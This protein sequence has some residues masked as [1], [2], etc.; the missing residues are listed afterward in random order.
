[1]Y[2][3]TA[4]DANASINIAAEFAAPAEPNFPMRFRN[5]AEFHASETARYE[6]KPVTDPTYPVTDEQDYMWAKAV[7]HNL[8]NMDGIVDGQK[9]IKQ[10]TNI[11]RDRMDRIEAVSWSFV[12]GTFRSSLNTSNLI[13]QRQT[14]RYHRILGPLD[15]TNPDNARSPKIMSFAEHMNMVLPHIRVTKTLCRHI[16][17]YFFLNTFIDGPDQTMFVSQ[18]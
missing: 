14:K 17:S 6:L 12:V 11:M 18:T 2:E 9:M 10:W 7:M 3:G 8:L 1:M 4:N 16:T 5:F 13:Q 15:P